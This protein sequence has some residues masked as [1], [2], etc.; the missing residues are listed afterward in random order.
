MVRTSSVSPLRADGRDRTIGFHRLESL[1]AGSSHAT[2]GTVTPSSSTPRACALRNR[3]LARS[4]CARRRSRALWAA[5]S[6]GSDGFLLTPSLLA[7]RRGRENSDTAHWVSHAGQMTSDEIERRSARQPRRERY[8]MRRTGVFMS[9]S[10]GVGTDH[11]RHAEY[12]DLCGLH[13]PW[14]RRDTSERRAGD[15][16]EPVAWRHQRRGRRWS[17]RWFAGW[18]TLR[19]TAEHQRSRG[20]VNARR[21]DRP[22]REFAANARDHLSEQPA[23]GSRADARHSSQTAAGPASSSAPTPSASLNMVWMVRFHRETPNLNLWP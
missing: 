14:H 17:G 22:S 10:T 23:R 9:T 3:R 2:F 1:P 7:E 5:L 6:R 15:T 11:A 20:E 4:A 16:A 19:A 18:P 13:N 8:L 21:T 12:H